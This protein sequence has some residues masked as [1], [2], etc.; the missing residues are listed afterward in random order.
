MATP[1]C[2][3][4]VFL[5]LSRAYPDYASRHLAGSEAVQTMQLYERALAD[6]TDVSLEAATLDHITSSVFF[7]KIAELRE[8]AT[9]LLINELDLP[10]PA[11]AWG[12]VVARMHKS[13]TVYRDGQSYR[14]RP[15]LQIIEDAV[16]A[17]GGWSYLR[18]SENAVS[19]RAQ[20]LAAYQSLAI[21]ERRR[22]TEHPAV[23]EAREQIAARARVPEVTDGAQ[24][25]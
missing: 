13:P 15:L 25:R 4:N 7:P 18:A 2:V 14:R 23:T 20:F 21:R 22:I 12:D 16:R 5:M 17:V 10:T 8:R 6:V 3:Q 11:Q 1:E 19:D 24:D 9:S